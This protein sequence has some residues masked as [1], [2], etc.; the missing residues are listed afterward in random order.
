DSVRI[1]SLTLILTSESNQGDDIIS[2]TGSAYLVTEE[3]DESINSDEFFD[4]R[5]IIDYSAETTTQF[6]LTDSSRAIQLIELP[7]AMMESWTDTTGGGQNFGML[8]DYDNASY[9][10][11]FTS[12]HSS[13]VGQWPRMAV[14]YY[15][16]A[17][18]SVFHDTLIAN[19][20][21]SLIDFN[22]SFD[23]KQLFVSSGYVTRSFFNFDLSKIPPTAAMATM[24]FEFKRDSIGSVKN[25]NKSEFMNVRTIT[26]EYNLLPYYEADSTFLIN[27]FYNPTIIETSDNV[28]GIAEISRGNASQNFLQDILNGDIPYGSFMFQYEV[29]G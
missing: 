29:E 19:K 11:E 16:A 12:R 7:P 8:L 21:A 3:W 2:L 23:P 22:G 17:L 20:D 5:T 18:D 26:T 15:D 1:D 9:I 28:L 27:I 25:N 13:F 14:A 4:Y 10:K 24:N 6:E